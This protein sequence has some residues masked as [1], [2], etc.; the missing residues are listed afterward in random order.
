MKIIQALTEIPD[1]SSLSFKI[2][3][4]KKTF[5]YSLFNRKTNITTRSDGFVLFGGHFV[6][7]DFRKIWKARMFVHIAPQK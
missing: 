2:P 1:F 5:P 4:S 3:L 6:R 7:N